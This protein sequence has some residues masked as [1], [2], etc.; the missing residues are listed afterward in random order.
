MHIIGFGRSKIFLDDLLRKY[1]V[2]D[3]PVNA[4]WTSS[5][6]GSGGISLNP[7]FLA[8][9]T[10]T[11]ANSS[12]VLHTTTYGLNMGGR[13]RHAVNYDIPRLELHAT[14]ARVASDTECIARFQMKQSS[15]EGALTT[16]GLG[17]EIQNL[18][19]MGESFG[20]ERG[21]VELLP[22]IN[23][24][25]YQIRIVHVPD[26]RIEFWVNGVLR[27]TLGKAHVPTGVLAATHLVAS[28][29]NGATGGTNCI[30]CVG[31]ITIIQEW[32]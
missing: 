4:N 16:S 18:R 14:I 32:R 10:G 3:I 12:A 27:A 28:I 25:V 7:C 22:A 2:L 8:V 13:P 29:R 24:T 1:K 17:L 21:T 20:T 30:F 15:T 5:V 11:T 31:P 23:D 6:T 26:V 9:N 19:L